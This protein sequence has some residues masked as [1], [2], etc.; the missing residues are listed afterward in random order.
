[1]L[2]RRFAYGDGGALLYFLALNIFV[3]LI[4]HVKGA[5]INARSPAQSDVRTAISSAK[6]GDTVAVPAGT[7]RWTTTLAINKPITL[8]GAGIGKT[9]IEDDLAGNGNTIVIETTSGQSYRLTGFEF[10]P[11]RR[12]A[13]R[14]KGLPARKGQFQNVPNR[15]LPV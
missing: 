15:S 9:I 3:S 10:K 7:A 13:K 4:V 12:A 14:R 8:E 6:D 5:V 1:M 2:N 11:G